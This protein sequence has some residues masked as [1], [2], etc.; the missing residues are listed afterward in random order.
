MAFHKSSPVFLNQEQ[1]S[2]AHAI[3][4]CYGHALTL[5]RL[6]TSRGADCNIVAGRQLVNLTQ[7]ETW[8]RQSMLSSF[9]FYFK[10]LFHEGEINMYT[11]RNRHTCHPLIHSPQTRRTWELSPGFPCLWQRPKCFSYHLLPPRLHVS[12]QTD[13]GMTLGPDQALVTGSGHPGNELSAAPNI[14]P[15]GSGLFWGSHQ[16]SC[17]RFKERGCFSSS[18]WYPYN[19]W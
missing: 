19:R 7:D 15:T 18:F 3:E 6:T 5:A 9:L 4:R 10:N 12:W 2:Q 14:H 13:L 1:T 17:K 16:A 11:K 8:P